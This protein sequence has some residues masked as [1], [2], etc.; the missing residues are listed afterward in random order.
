MTI[1]PLTTKSP[2]K[3]WLIRRD[4]DQKYMVLKFSEGTENLASLKQENVALKQK[5]VVDFYG[6]LTTDLG[7]G[8]LMEYCPGGNLASLVQHRSVFTLGESVTALAPIAQTISGLHAHGIRHGDISPA[9]ILLTAQGMPKIIDFQESSVS[10]IQAPMAGTPGFIAP[11]VIHGGIEQNFGDQDV[12]AL[13]ACLWFLLCGNAP[14]DLH[15]RAPVRVQFPDIPEIVQCLLVDSLSD[16]PLERPSA[17]QFA[18]TLFTSAAAEPIHWEG[19]IDPETNHLMETVHSYDKP[20]SH[21]RKPRTR[22]TNP[23]SGN[24]WHGHELRR[25]PGALKITSSAIAALIVF[26]GGAYAVSSLLSGQE[27]SPLALAAQPTEDS[28]C[29]IKDVS[30]V[31]ACAFESDTVISS[32]LTLSAQRDQAMN[33][34]DLNALNDIYVKGSEQLSRDQ[35]TLKQLSKL[36]LSIQGLNT[37]LRD[38]RVIARGAGDVVILGAKSTMNDFK[39]VDSDGKTLHEVAAG[40]EEQIEVQV[41]LVE[42]KWRLGNVLSRQK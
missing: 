39:Y 36:G 33:T 13:G 25:T 7:D 6:I 38:L 19:H 10:Q 27:A 29:H 31:P 2:C 16:D 28:S 4:S 8:L 1:K 3:V 30:Y 9:N 41:Q 26:S 18:R 14:G 21:R 22:H 23:E 15:T 5:Y 35:Q 24:Q 11:E 17:E 40:G 37:K 42:G 32:F 34:K 12:Y 20:G